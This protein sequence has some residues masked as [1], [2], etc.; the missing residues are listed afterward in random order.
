MTAPTFMRSRILLI[1]GFA[2]AAAPAAA[3]DMATGG[4]DPQGRPLWE[5][6]A[7]GG[8]TWQQAYPGSSRQVNRALVLPWLVYRGRYLR[9]DSESVGLRAVRTPRY[10]LDIS[11]AGAFGSRAGDDPV[12]AGM[13][14]LGTMV[15]IGPRL[16]V[17][18]GGTPEDGRW[19]LDLP[20][21]GVYDL[22][23]SL[24][25]RGAVFQPGISWTRRLPGAWTVGASASL[26]FAD[27]KLSRTFY[28]VAPA[29]ANALRPAYHAEAGLM[30]TRLSASLSRRL[31]ADWTLFGF[32]RIDS[33]AGAANRASPLVTRTTGATLGL[34]ASWTWM[35]SA[36]A[37]NE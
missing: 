32:A 17:N 2:I 10:E 21:R 20:L 5:I 11:A 16:R 12:R 22:S 33:V 4:P 3:Q 36:Q 8:A 19:R 34:G 35:R 27:A 7:A 30:S 18:L 9:A 13:P 24:A 14:D 1:A 29:H 28:D 26:T 31:S 25:Y 37:A 6:G 15:E 23:D